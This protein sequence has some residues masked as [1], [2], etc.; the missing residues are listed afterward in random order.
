MDKNKM[1][2]K[3]KTQKKGFTLLE[4]LIVIGILAILA[5]VAI[6]VINPAEL[7][8]RARDSQ[9]ISDLNSLKS[10]I[11]IYLIDIAS[12][13]LDAAQSVCG[14]VINLSM[15]SGSVCGNCA[16]ANATNYAKING[17]GWVPVN[18]GSMSTGSPL[19]SLPIDPVNASSTGARNQLYYTYTCNNTALTFL[20]GARLESAF[21]IG[22]QTNG[23]G[24]MSKDGGNASS[25]LE[26]GTAMTGITPDLTTTYWG[27][28]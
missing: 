8:R 27:V 23:F 2:N 24:P 11:G 1:N 5:T 13:D 7:L 28:I 16:L 6:L 14:S 12:P 26:V 25:V 3:C 18:F 4:L 17:T 9:R 21:F 10:A 20:M 22:N 19:G 15:T